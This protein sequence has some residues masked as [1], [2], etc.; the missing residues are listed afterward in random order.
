MEGRIGK[1]I[2]NKE[3]GPIVCFEIVF[4]IYERE[5]IQGNIKNTFF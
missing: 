5:S 1:I 3:P 2:R 4:S